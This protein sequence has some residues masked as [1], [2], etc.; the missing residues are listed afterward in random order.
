MLE[1]DGENIKMFAKYNLK[2]KNGRTQ[3][4]SRDASSSCI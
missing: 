1:N 2:I 4:L 3:V